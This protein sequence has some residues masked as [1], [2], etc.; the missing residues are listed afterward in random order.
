MGA[1]RTLAQQ[2]QAC[3]FC[4]DEP[5]VF[6]ACHINIFL[7]VDFAVY[8]EKEQMPGR[9]CISVLCRTA[10]RT[11]P[12]PVPV[13]FAE[14]EQH[15]GGSG[16]ALLMVFDQTG[17][18]SAHTGESLQGLSLQIQVST[19]D[20]DAA[21]TANPPHPFL[22]AWLPG[23]ISM[24]NLALAF[25]TQPRLFKELRQPL[26]APK[27]HFH[28]WVSPEPTSSSA[29]N[30]RHSSAPPCLELGQELK[31][32]HISTA[33]KSQQDIT[34]FPARSETGKHFHIPPWPL[35]SPATC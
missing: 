16:G 13:C 24:C 8:W 18:E 5:A 10:T 12:S 22:W 23:P 3:P 11:L 4:F 14:G 1:R 17:A 21:W 15:R 9:M 28:G 6:L 31:Q 32:L 29:V 34:E 27:C 30:S 26:V 2:S 33:L 20:Q 35:S 7:C 25:Q 19:W